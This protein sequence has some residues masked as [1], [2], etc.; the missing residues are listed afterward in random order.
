M[1]SRDLVTSLVT[2]VI[3]LVA[4]SMLLTG[5]QKGC[6]TKI[7]HALCTAGQTHSAPPAPAP[8]GAWNCF[9]ASGGWNCKKKGVDATLFPTNPNK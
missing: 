1:T 8:S 6:D 9:H 4:A 3:T 5:C 2:P 7:G